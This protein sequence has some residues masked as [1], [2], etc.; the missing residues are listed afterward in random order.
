MD[1][2]IHEQR[3][4]ELTAVYALLVGKRYDELNNEQLRVLLANEYW[5]DGMEI[6]QVFS[7]FIYSK[8]E[9][10][11]PVEEIKTMLKKVFGYENDSIIPPP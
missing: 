4:R 10:A 6:E 1:E 5:K 8:V 3:V 9:D 2:S 11:M 7:E